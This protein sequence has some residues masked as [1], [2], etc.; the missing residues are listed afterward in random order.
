L[1]SGKIGEGMPPFGLPP[2]STTH[3]NVTYSFTDMVVALD[4]SLIAIPLIAVLESVAI[5]KAFG[6][7]QP[8]FLE[9]RRL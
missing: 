9:F 7:F 4:T 8:F 5:A 3:N 2:F 6:K 1:F